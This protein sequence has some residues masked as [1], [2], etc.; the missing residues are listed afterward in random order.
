[1]FGF[2]SRRAAAALVL[3]LAAATAP[4]VATAQSFDL[5]PEQPGRPRAEKVEAIAAAVPKDFRFIEDG[6]LTVA[7]APGQPPIATYATD[8]RTVIGADP[9]LIQLVADL[10]GLKLKIVAVAWADWPLGL[11]SGKYDAVISNVGV[12]EERKQRFDFSTYRKGL[13]G[14]YVK[15]GSPITAIREPKDIAGLRIITSSGTIQ[16]KILLEWDRQNRAQGLAPAE[17]QYYDDEAAWN[18]AVQSGRADAMFSVNAA[19]AYQAAREGNLKQVGTVSAGWPLTAETGITT[20]RGSGLA[21]PL[22]AAL[23]EL[24]ADGRY[25]AV[26]ARW[27]LTAEAVDRSRTNPPGL[28]KF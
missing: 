27:N 8:A 10:L 14:F 26:L 9:D 12:T 23:N 22:T 16:E 19:L 11:S 25:A 24:I 5:S 3:G 6:V 17:L 4:G 7:I 15:S 28:P 13:H 2:M 21:D 20:R 1:M 18:L